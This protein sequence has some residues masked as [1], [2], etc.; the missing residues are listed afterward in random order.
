MRGVKKDLGVHLSAL[1]RHLM[2][3]GASLVATQKCEVRPLSMAPTYLACLFPFCKPGT[4][5][6][7]WAVLELRLIASAVS[8]EDRAPVGWGSHSWGRLAYWPPR[9]GEAQC[10]SWAL[11]GPTPA[12]GPGPPGQGPSLGPP[13][14]GLL[15]PRGA[16]HPSHWANPNPEGGHVAIP[17]QAPPRACSVQ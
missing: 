4:L 8:F 14:P 16:L 6:V 15:V 7:R 1:Q 10:G 9:G 3:F 13:E 2:A 12:L 11:L 5:S 17:W